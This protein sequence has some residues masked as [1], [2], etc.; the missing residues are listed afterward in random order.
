MRRQTTKV[1]ISAVGDTITLKFLQP[2]ADTKLEGYI[3]GYGSR[4]FSKQLIQLP[5][6]GEPYETEIGNM[7]TFLF[8]NFSLH[9]SHSLT[10]CFTLSDAEPKY[11]IAVQPVNGEV[12][13]QCTGKQNQC[14]GVEGTVK[15]SGV[16]KNVIHRVV[17]KHT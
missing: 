15:G 16:I 2:H 10:C 11:L 3:L 7:P 5:E 17:A 12:K 1:R 14:E 9:P 4:L 13:K 8:D 6:D